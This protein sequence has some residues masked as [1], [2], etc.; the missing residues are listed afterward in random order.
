[1]ST[2]YV[3]KP[4]DTLS[5]IALA[6]HLPS[7]RNIY[8]DP[9]NKT[10]KIR[11]PDPTIIFPGDV[12]MIPSE[13]K[14]I[15]P[16]T[17]TVLSPPITRALNLVYSFAK[18]QRMVEN[19][20]GCFAT[21]GGEFSQLH[22]ATIAAELAE[23]VV[24]P[25]KINQ[26]NV[27]ICVPA[28]LAYELA[29]TRPEDYVKAVTELFDNGQTTLGKWKLTPN[30]DLKRYALP[31]DTIGEADWIIMASVRDSE[32]WF[33]DYSSV[34]DSGGTTNR[35]YNDMLSKAGFTEIKDDNSNF[36]HEDA[37]NLKKADELYS[38]N[39]QV[40]LRIDAAA[41]TSSLSFAG[42]SNHRV[43][44]ASNIRTKFFALSSPVSMDVFTWGGKETLPRP[45][46]VVD[47]ARSCGIVPMTLEKF[48]T[49]YYGYTAAKY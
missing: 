32:N 17:G 22:R 8:D 30:E 4:G 35:E 49:Y 2:R 9:E 42:K 47:D 15:D 16:I 7:Y 38:K 27:D 41:L 1:M 13:P 37:D 43:V 20:R 46:L 33:F 45:G 23:R 14:G 34:K 5:K 28:A 31:K 18:K 40:S 19:S 48:L 26:G 10:F 29:K 36:G 21:S 12:L 24:D 39:Y 25:T 11:H 3:V 44:L 6:Y